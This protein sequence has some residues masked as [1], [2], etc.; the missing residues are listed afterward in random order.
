MATPSLPAENTESHSATKI[1]AED[2]NLHSETED[3][4]LTKE[5]RY[6]REHIGLGRESGDHGFS[7]PNLEPLFFIEIAP[8]SARGAQCKFPTCDKKIWPRE[9]RLALNPGINYGHWYTSSIGETLT[10]S[11]YD[12]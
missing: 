8:Y 7:S 5:R 6:L 1:D 2:A 9:L 4:I 12:K 10:S 11:S 3:D